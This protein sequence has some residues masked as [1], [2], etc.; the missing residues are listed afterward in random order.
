MVVAASSPGGA[1]AIAPAPSSLDRFLTR[2]EQALPLRDGAL[3]LVAVI[4]L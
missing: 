1:A 3:S 4:K 2:A